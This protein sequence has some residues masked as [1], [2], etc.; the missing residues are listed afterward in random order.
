V[1]NRAAIRMQ[2]TAE[3]FSTMSVVCTSKLNSGN[4]QITTVF[5]KLQQVRSGHGQLYPD[6][7]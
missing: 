7:Q 1:T 2:R 3:M 4:V 6:R 5:T